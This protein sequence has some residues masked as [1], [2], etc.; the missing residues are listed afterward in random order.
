MTNRFAGL[1]GDAPAPTEPVKPE[2][3]AAAKAEKP[4]D[5]TLGGRV[6]DALF[7]E[8]TRRKA[9][10]EEALGVRKVTTEQGLEALVRLLRQEDLRA[11]W[12]AEVQAV[13]KDHG[14]DD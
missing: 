6:P 1:S 3:A 10:A 4:T 12:L 5:R 11:A 7:R 8:F 2:P 9:D 14:V 13:R